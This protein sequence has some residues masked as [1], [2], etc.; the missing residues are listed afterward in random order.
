MNL[1]AE[2]SLVTAENCIIMISVLAP[3][4][5]PLDKTI[6]T[7]TTATTQTRQQQQGSTSIVIEITSH[8]IIRVTR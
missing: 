4:I 7:G 5:C 2:S 3:G 6:K 1:L 8:Q